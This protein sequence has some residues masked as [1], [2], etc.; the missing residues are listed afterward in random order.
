MPSQGFSPDGPRV[1]LLG[2]QTEISN[3]IVQAKERLAD[4]RSRNAQSVAF[5]PGNLTTH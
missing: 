4:L 5:T 3:R 1:F 2:L